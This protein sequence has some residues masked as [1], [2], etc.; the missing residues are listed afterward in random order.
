MDDKIRTYVAGR[1]SCGA[2]EQHKQFVPG[3]N[4]TRIYSNFREIICRPI[5][6]TCIT[7]KILE[8]IVHSNIMQH[9]ETNEVN[10][11]QH[12]FRKEEVVQHN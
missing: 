8:H 7:C 12:G 3:L 2:G 5:S 10:E 9:L 4:S 1:M 11:T 6:L